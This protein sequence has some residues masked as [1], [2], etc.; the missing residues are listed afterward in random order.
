MGIP[1]TIEQLRE[2]AWMAKHPEPAQV[3]LLL[4]ERGLGEIDRVADEVRNLHDARLGQAQYVACMLA[5]DLAGQVGDLVCAVTQRNPHVNLNGCDPRSE[6]QRLNDARGAQY[7]DTAYDAQPGIEGPPRDVFPVFATDHEVETASAMRLRLHGQYLRD[8]L[9]HHLAGYRIDRRL[10]NRHPKPGSSHDAHPLAGK[11]AGL[12]RRVCAHLGKHRCT[13]GVVRIVTAVLEHVC[14]SDVPANP[15]HATDGDA[16]EMRTVRQAHV[17][18][19]TTFVVKQQAQRRLDS[20]RRATA[21]RAPAAQP[22]RRQQIEIKLLM[23][24]HVRQSDSTHR[25]SAH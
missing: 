1:C 14:A 16:Q 15:T 18:L 6:R 25:S 2:L 13:V 4:V 22:I 3:T 10:A 8:G 9:A 23:R 5:T 21:R 11:E 12:T 7:R 19:L 24:V 17:N 20:S